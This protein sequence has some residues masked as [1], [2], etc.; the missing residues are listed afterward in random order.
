MKTNVLAVSDENGL[1]KVHH[2]FNLSFDQ[3]RVSVR[4][5]IT[6]RVFYEVQKHNQNTAEYHHCLVMPRQEERALNQPKIVDAEKQLIVAFEAFQNNG[7]FMLV[8]DRQAESLD[9]EVVVKVGASVSFV[10]L[11]PLVGG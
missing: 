9:E 2:T 7:F 4:D 8:N 3:A 11:T 6:E 1:G 5:I 10:K